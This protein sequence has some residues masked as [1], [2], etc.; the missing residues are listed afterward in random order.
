MAHV[1]LFVLSFFP[2]VIPDLIGD[3]GFCP[4]TPALSRQGRGGVTGNGHRMNERLRLVRSGGR[5]GLEIV[6]C[7]PN[8]DEHG[9]SQQGGQH[10][11]TR[12]AQAVHDGA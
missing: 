10:E 12:V 3:P 7:L 5:G 2:S 8:K 11:E 6:S 4:L 9:Q 1:R